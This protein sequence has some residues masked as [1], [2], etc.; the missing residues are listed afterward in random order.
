M[1]LDERETNSYWLAEIQLSALNVGIYVDRPKDLS[2]EARI[3]VSAI[4]GSTVGQIA[5]FRKALAVAEQHAKRL[6]RRK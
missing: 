4:R 1:K 2:R 5:E 3:E 6:N